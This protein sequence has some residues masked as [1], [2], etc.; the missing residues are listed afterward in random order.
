M[1]RLTDLKRTT[2]LT[3]K[4]QL[5]NEDFLLWCNELYG[6]LSEISKQE[7]KVLSAELRQGEYTIDREVE[8][9]IETLTVTQDSIDLPS[10]FQQIIKVEGETDGRKYV[11]YQRS[12]G[13]SEVTTKGNSPNH[14]RLPYANEN[15]L[16]YIDY[17]EDKIIFKSNILGQNNMTMNVYFYKTLPLYDVDEDKDNLEQLTIPFDKNYHKLISYYAIMKYYETWQDLESVMFYK[18]DYLRIREEYESSVLRRHQENETS[19][20]LKEALWH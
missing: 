4:R 6:E 10:N 12:F 8:G 5:E 2:E 15:N 16:Y 17:I 20:Q 1:S 3:I 9:E 7:A 11:F 13:D 14:T 19:E 18:G